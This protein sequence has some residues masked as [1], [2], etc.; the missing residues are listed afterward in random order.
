M[1]HEAILVLTWKSEDTIAKEDGVGFW[2]LYERKARQ[3][4]YVVCARNA[5]AH[6]VEGPEPHRAAFLIG[7]IKEVVR[8]PQYQGRVLIRLEEYAR[9]DIPNAWKKG[10]RNPVT[11][12]TLE[13]LKVDL[14]TLDW[15]PM[16]KVS[17][18]KTIKSEETM[19][20]FTIRDAKRS[21]AAMLGV[22][23]DAIEITIRA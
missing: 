1:P 2:R 5:K 21:L 18:H 17:L 6:H 10:Q 15:K 22:P 4:E 13:K 12:T 16:P 20:A 8:V 23:P 14:A 9:I 7:K 11:Y 19:P 3:Y